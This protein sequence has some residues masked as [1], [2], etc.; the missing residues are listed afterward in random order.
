MVGIAKTTGPAWPRFR[1]RCRV[2]SKMRVGLG[3]QSPRGI[4]T[5]DRSAVQ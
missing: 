1:F 2:D 4:D 3:P 5:G